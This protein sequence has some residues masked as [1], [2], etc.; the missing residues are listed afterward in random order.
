M[1]SRL[2]IQNASGEVI[3]DRYFRFTKARNIYMRD[4]K[5]EMKHITGWCFVV[6]P[7]DKMNLGLDIFYDLLLNDGPTNV[8]WFM[9]KYEVNEESIYTAISLL[10][11]PKGYLMIKF[12]T[13]DGVFYNVMCLNQPRTIKEHLSYAI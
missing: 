2:K 9:D 7:D 5:Y 12:D 3:K 8:S 6:A 1:G 13:P 10:R 11:M 4:K